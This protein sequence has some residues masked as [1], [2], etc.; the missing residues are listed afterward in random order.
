MSSNIPSNI[1]NK[2]LYQQVKEDIYNKYPKHSAYRS[3]LLNKEYKEKG[4]K[5]KN[6]NDKRETTTWLKEKWINLTPYAEGLIK[7]INQSP[8]CGKKHPNQK[9]PSVCRPS[10]KV[11]NN[12]PKL[13]S[14]YSKQ[15]IK[16]A[17]DIKKQ[18]KRINWDKL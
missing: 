10:V 9:S 14:N 4:G 13:A 15:Q 8:V 6:I 3:M 12:T 1:I 2:K 16:K 17:V 11:N 18:N 7:S 5:Y